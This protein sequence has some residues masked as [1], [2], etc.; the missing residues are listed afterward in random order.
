MGFGDGAIDYIQR[1]KAG[2][3]ALIDN[4]ARQAEGDMKTVAPWRDR[5]STARR[6][7]HTGTVKVGDKIV[8]YMA[9]GV[10]YGP[11][12]EEG[13]PPHV[14]RAKNKKALYW[15]GAGHPVKAVKHPGT[16]PHAA[17]RPTADKYKIKVHDTLMKWWGTK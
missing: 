1:K 11:Y 13:T 9:H 14:I 17:V 6:A 2:T 7:L 3:L 15:R 4:L 12:L 10:K 5:T 8:M 16:K